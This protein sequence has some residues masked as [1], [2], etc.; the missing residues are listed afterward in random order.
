M[1]QPQ[2]KKEKK[3]TWKMFTTQDLMNDLINRVNKLENVSL[4]K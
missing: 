3:N 2:N 4:S 1:C